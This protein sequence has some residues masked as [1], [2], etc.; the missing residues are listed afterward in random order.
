MDFETRKRYYNRC[1]PDEPL[2][3]DDERNVDLDEFGVRGRGEPWVER[4]AGQIELS[5]NPVFQLFTGL[6]GSGKSTELRRLAEWLRCEDRAHLLP[7]LVDAETSIDLAN[8]VDVPEILAS[9]LLRTEQEVLVLEG[10]GAEDALQE[11]Y[12]TRLWNWLT[13]TDVELKNVEFAVPS[14]AKLLAELK[15]RPSLR[16]RVRS[17]IAAHLTRFLDEARA[18]LKAL[19][20][21]AC[22]RGYRGL[23]VIFDSLE[24][25]RGMST[26]WSDVLNSAERMFAAGAPYLRLP[27]HVLYTIPTALVL[28]RVEH[29]MFLPMIKLHDQERRPFEQGMR[30]ARELVRLRVPD[31]VLEQLLGEH[32]E[33]RIKVLIRWSGGYPRELVRLLREA[34]AVATQPV[35]ENDLRRIVNDLKEAY[36]RTVPAEAFAWLARVEIER[37]LTIKDD[38]HRP[39]A[40][41]M[42]SNNAVLRYLNDDEWYELHPAVRDIPGVVEEREKL[43]AMQQPAAADD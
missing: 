35:P 42:L 2:S 39:A 17:T 29:V 30:A 28:R 24:K 43:R 27:V 6:P 3:P 23:I 10:R 15:T 1:R 9:I 34:F 7:V 21:R 4:L 11:G 13:A 31:D 14:A 40:D 20:Q 36:R 25:L 8:P 32:C 16:H 33:E 41:L 18:E 5:D 37:Y 26:N 19:E 12:L 38:T 22:A